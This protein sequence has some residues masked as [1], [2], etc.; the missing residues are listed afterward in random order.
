MQAPPAEPRADDKLERA[1]RITRENPYDLE[2]WSYL[3]HQASSWQV[4][5][6]RDVYER[7]VS[8][9]NTSGRFWKQYIEQEVT[10]ARPVGSYPRQR[11]TV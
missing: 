4:D 8:V 9:F 11:G 1:Q 5:A 6:A 7:L 10:Q 2:G 3:L